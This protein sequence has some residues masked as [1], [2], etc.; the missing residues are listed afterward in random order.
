MQKFGDI[1]G[2]NEGDIYNDRMQIKNLGI[3]KYH[4]NGISR[5]LNEG[6]DAIVLNG[7]YID[8]K[9]EGDIIY[10][11]GEGGR[12]EGA[13]NQEYDQP[14]TKGN[15][16]L[17]MNKFTK[18]PIRVIRGF[19]LRDSEYTPETGYRYDGLYLL[20]DYWPEKGIDGFLIWRYK[21][22]KVNSHI[23][24]KK[25]ET[26]NTERIQAKINRIVRN[27]DIPKTLKKKYDFTCQVCGIRLESN[28]IPYA[29]GAHIRGL[30]YPHNGPDDI[31]NM[32]ILCPNDHYLFDSFAFSINDDLSFTGKKERLIKKSSHD[33]NLNHIQY[34]RK[35]Y[36]LIQKEKK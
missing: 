13:T 33:I 8:D 15:L 25:E 31:S 6:C 24:N 30:G 10:Y 21:L 27:H 3:H 16:D 4:I 32:L 19:N 5:I 17:S 20:E 23:P 11:T 2:I 26:R 36:D 29:I 28:N 1:L 34:H 12:P 18:Q 9:D 22:V 35:L 14:L 7:G